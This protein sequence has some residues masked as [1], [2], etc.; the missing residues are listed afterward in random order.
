MLLSYLFVFLLAAIPL[1]E[2]VAVIPLAIIGGLS[3]VLTAI[4]AF[5]GNALTVVLLIVFVDQVKKW[6][7]KRKQKKTYARY[8]P[9]GRSCG[10]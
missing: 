7:R 5:L 4:L 6:M 10:D 9:C 3:P 8:Y 1:F 2:L